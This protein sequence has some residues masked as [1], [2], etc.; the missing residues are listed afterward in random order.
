MI[1]KIES[2]DLMIKLGRSIGLSLAGGELIELVGDV[3]TGKTTLVKGIAMGMGVDE[4]VQSPS[5]TISRVY[6][7]RDSLLLAHYDFY[8]LNDAGIMLEELKE[9]IYDSKT[10]T[11]IEW[12]GV[13]EGILPADKL[14]ISLATID[15]NTRTVDIKSGGLVSEKLVG[16][17]KT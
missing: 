17:I 9:K 8:R 2:E 4:T 16:Q 15:E 11:V 5:F 6:Q 13:G 14:T 7:A 12:G 10:V 1:R 3:G